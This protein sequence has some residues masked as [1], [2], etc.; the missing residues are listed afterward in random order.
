MD[1][2][3]I[4]NFLDSDSEMGDFSSGS[5]EVYEPSEVEE[6]N[7]NEPEEIDVEISEEIYD[8]SNQQPTGI[9]IWN[10]PDEKFVPKKNQ[11]LIVPVK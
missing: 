1:E 6:E 8:Q 4:R 9:F 5:G 11:V 2:E 10:R 7:Y 3:E